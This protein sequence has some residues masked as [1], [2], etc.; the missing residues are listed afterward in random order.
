MPIEHKKGSTMIT[1]DSID[2]FRLLAQ[3]G[4]VKLECKGIKMTRG[5]VV[6]KRVKAE[7]GIK[8]NREAVLAWLEAKVKEMREQQEHIDEE[9]RRSVGGMEVQ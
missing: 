8:G 1:G 4:A 9:G 3:R 7:Y 2:F 5:P 6:W